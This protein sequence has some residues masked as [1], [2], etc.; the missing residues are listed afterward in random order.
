MLCETVTPPRRAHA[1]SSFTAPP[2]APDGV[3]QQRCQAAVDRLLARHSWRLLAPDEFVRRTHAHLG[4][5]HAADPHRAAV[6]AYSHALHAACS[7]GEGVAR[8]DQGYTELFRYLYDSAV[9]RYPD[10]CDDTTQRA[11]E[12]TFTMFGRCR[13]PGAFFAF[14]LQQLMDAARTLRRQ[15][16]GHPWSLDAPVGE[17]DDTLGAVLPD[18]AARDPVGQVLDQERQV[19]VRRLVREFT[20]A[21]P[22]ARQQLA[23]LWLKHMEGFD[24]TAISQKLGKPARSLYV[25]RSR[26]IAKLQMDSGWQT[27]ARECG[28]LV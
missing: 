8:Q 7:G 9:R 2:T 5:G 12:R 15:E 24:D 21:H 28:M 10:I 3:G 26:A 6:Y 19:R 22:R 27:L 20:R 1:L 4:A 13:E 25:L 18:R 11:L 14:A 23:A 16:E 17:G